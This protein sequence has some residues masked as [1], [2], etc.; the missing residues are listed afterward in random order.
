MLSAL[1]LKNHRVEHELDLV[2]EI[3]KDRPEIVPS[4]VYSLDLEVTGE[5]H[6]SK[7]LACVS[8]W[9]MLISPCQQA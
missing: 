7:V 1:S 4:K 3:W 6:A 2:G 9:E 8:V 5:D